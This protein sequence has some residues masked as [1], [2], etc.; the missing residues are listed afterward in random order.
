MQARVEEDEPRVLRL[1]AA[2]L[3]E[4][5]ALMKE[6]LKS[7]FKGSI[8]LRFLRW[9][10][11]FLCCLL[12]GIAAGLGFFRKSASWDKRSVK[13]ILA[14]RIDRIGDL[15]LT[16]PALRALK[17]TY[18]E[19]HLA[20]L[21]R[22]GTK[23]L[24]EHSSFVDQVIVVEDFSRRELAAFLRGLGFDAAISFH[25]DVF[26]N[27]LAWQ[28]GIPYRVGYACC[29][30]GFFLTKVLADDRDVRIR[31]EVQS[32]LEV[33]GCLGARTND[34]SLS[35]AVS[36]EAEAFVD[37]FYKKNG[38]DAGDKVVIIHP[39]SR[40]LHLRWQKEKFAA[41]ADRLIA[42]K[43]CHV[44]VVG[45]PRETALVDDVR[46]LMREAP[47]EAVGL[48]LPQLISVIKRGRVFVGHSTGPMHIAAALKVPV[49]AIFGNVHPLDSWQEWGPWGEGH[50]VVRKNLS[51]PSCH[52][53]D[54]RLTSRNAS[55]GRTLACM[56]AV[57]VDDVFQAVST[58]LTRRGDDHV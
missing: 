8:F 15:I 42:E 31:H 46:K 9:L 20:V 27:V 16:T 4:K 52:P 25:P 21:V 35:V 39:G 50:V 34:F 29:G 28:A 7:V 57:T 47:V 40:Q 10:R 37:E 5:R 12:D 2:S 26:A 33:A 6:L 13:K 38:F 1:A 3:F 51:C 24:V 49:V 11:G 19:S 55:D 14:I 23:D 22:R 41:L 43:Q 45:G 32:A 56:D 48:T 36:C 30:S 58:I 17:E 54:C 18:P 44:L 53:G